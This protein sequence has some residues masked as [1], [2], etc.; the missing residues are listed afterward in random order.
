M[1]ASGLPSC[2]GRVG[3]FSVPYANSGRAPELELAP[4]GSGVKLED[5][6]VLHTN[7]TTS[8]YG[9]WFEG[10]DELQLR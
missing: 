8:V 10:A 6:H 4:R 7:S 3:A 1:S 2:C 5:L 9:E